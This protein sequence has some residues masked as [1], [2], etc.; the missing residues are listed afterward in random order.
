MGPFL[1]FRFRKT[2]QVAYFPVWDR[3]SLD[4]LPRV[5]FRDIQPLAQ[6]IQG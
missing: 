3:V 5:P 6:L 4:Q 1:D 2:K